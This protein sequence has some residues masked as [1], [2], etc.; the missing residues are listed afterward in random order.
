M[1][2][3]KN[4][5]KVPVPTSTPGARIII[6]NNRY[7]YM[8]TKATWDNETQNSTDD[9]KAIGKLCDDDDSMMW[10][11]KYYIKE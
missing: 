11:N 2:L 9:S 4:A 3:A 6:Y 10:A 8:V 7:V 5:V 1:S